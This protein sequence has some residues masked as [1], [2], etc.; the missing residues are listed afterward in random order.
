MVAKTFTGGAK[1]QSYLAELA[2]KA[3]RSAVVSA[4]IP[5]DAKY[6]DGTSVAM[7]AAIQEWGAPSRGIPPRPFFRPMVAEGEQHWGSDVA[8]WLKAKNYDAVAALTEVGHQME[9]ELR[10]SIIAVTSPALSPVTLLLRERF[11]T[12]PQDIKFS[13]VSQAREDIA[14]GITPDVTGT[15]SHPLMWTK[16]MFDSI[17]SMVDAK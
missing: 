4:G 6:P 11:W 3:D 1:L 12:N 10:E 16:T 9:D 5:A 2:K 13:D 14:S 8:N 7:I 15:Q 17:K